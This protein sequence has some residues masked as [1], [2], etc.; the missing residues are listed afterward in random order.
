MVFRGPIQISH[1]A[2]YTQQAGSKIK[3]SRHAHQ[4]RHGHLHDQ[5]EVKRDAEAN[6][7]AEAKLEERQEVV[8]TIDGKVVSWVNNYHPDAT[9]APATPAQP[10]PIKAAMGEVEEKAPAPQVTANVGA[11]NWARTAFYEAS[12]GTAT[13]LSF[14][15]NNNWGPL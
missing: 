14:L 12:S 9:P 1:I 10:A 2:V 6:S 13:G 3:R 5:M 8:A 4:R 11:G 7:E 15:Q